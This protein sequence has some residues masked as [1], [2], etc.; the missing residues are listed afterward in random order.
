MNEIESIR[1]H[2]LEEV[3]ETGLRTFVEVG[4]AL[5]EIRDSRLYRRDFSTFEDYCRDRWGMVRRHANRLIA[6]AEV[7]ENLGPIWSQIS[8]SQARTLTR[9]EPET[10]RTVWAEAVA[11]APNGKVTAAHVSATVERM[12]QPAH[13]PGSELLDV[14]KPEPRTPHV[15]NNSGNNEWYTPAAF[16]DAARHLMGRI[17]LDPA[18][19]AEANVVVQAGTFYTAED[20]G[21]AQSW[22]G[23]IWMNPPY[24]QPLINQFCDKLA[25][26]WDAEEFPEGIVLVNNAT[27]TAW[28]QT[29]IA[30]AS[31]VVF[32]RT[33]IKFWQPSGELGAPLQGQAV[34]YFGDSPG[35]FLEEFSRFGWGAYCDIR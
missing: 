8:E 24:A 14:E 33:R 6:A 22:F 26:E 13:D 5:L 35:A 32:P 29:L 2:R 7:V 21:L 16:V 17:D 12:T 15:S 18:S 19:C 30:R 1:L 28:F 25:T 34:I 4:N 3:I 10:Q 27:E 11:S 20:D 31:A 9:L 23:R